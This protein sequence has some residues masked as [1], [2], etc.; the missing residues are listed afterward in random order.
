MCP[1]MLWSRDISHI[2][3]P[4]LSFGLQEPCSGSLCLLAQLKSAEA[5]GKNCFPAQ[6]QEGNLGSLLNSPFPMGR[7][8]DSALGLLTQN[9]FPVGSLVL[10][11]CSGIEKGVGDRRVWPHGLR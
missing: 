2:P 10:F 8:R 11:P 1:P 4:F 6:K 5:G 7:T 9:S 3:I